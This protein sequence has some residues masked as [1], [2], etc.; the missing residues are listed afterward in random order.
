MTT[1]ILS[2]APSVPS[3]AGR[4]TGYAIAAGVVVLFAFYGTYFAQML[5]VLSPE[6]AA[7]AQTAD[8]VYLNGGL[9]VFVLSLWQAIVG[10]GLVAARTLS[11]LASVLAL[12]MAFRVARQLSGDIVMA[13]FL[14]L[15]FVLYP[16]L[17]A[18]WITATPHALFLL[19]AFGVFALLQYT[20]HL[21]AVLAAC[22]LAAIATLL[23]PLGL[24]AM[25]VWALFIGILLADKRALIVFGVTLGAAAG[26]MI[27]GVSSVADA[28]VSAA[29]H[30]TILT[31]MVRPY[32]MVIVGTGLSA[33]AALSAQTRQALGVRSTLVV[34]LGPVIATCI[35]L[36][37]HMVG[38][39]AIGQ[40]VTAAAYLFPL[41][42]LAPWPLIYWVRR[43]MPQV[44][45]IVAWI[46]FP[47]IMYSCF[48]VVLGPINPDRFPY[49]HRHIAQPQP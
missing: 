2:S 27:M 20:Q 35:L 21:A 10:T 17:V 3:F 7:L 28:D 13:A 9:Y 18:T 42:F 15:P 30:G 39:L 1:T 45:N 23:H 22:A 11:L 41:V 43:V 34:L 44:K 8:G 19:C 14:V 5:V 16:P 24:I 37:A 47:V 29:N 46:S 40:L 12:V 38:A 4:S 36:S 25:P 31:A 48:W 6:Q 26:S 32:A 49:S 33:I